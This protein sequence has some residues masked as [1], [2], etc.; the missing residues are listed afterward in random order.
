MDSSP[1]HE[2]A[3]GLREG[4]AEAWR[5]FY[6]AHAERL[7]FWVA[8]QV[9]PQAADVADVVQET[10]LAAARSAASFDPARGTLWAWLVGIGRNHVAL[11]YRKLQQ[12]Q[13]LIVMGGQG[14][15][16][17]GQ[18]VDWLETRE[19]PPA[20][21]VAT[22]EMAAIVRAA[23]ADLQADYGTLLTARYLEETS[24]E[25]LAE[26][27]QCTTTALRSKLA[28]ARRAFREAFKKMV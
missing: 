26:R 20:G 16:A 1:E 6:D 27:E 11:H 13:R 17:N 24:I 10:F 8:R 18:A 12:R 23:L 5:A 15:V 22:A 4:S 14:R 25:E 28:R 21:L 9:G 3:R 7:W 19:P 2:T